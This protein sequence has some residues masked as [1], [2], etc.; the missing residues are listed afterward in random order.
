MPE[1]KTSYLRDFLDADRLQESLS[2][3]FELLRDEEYDAIA[4]SG[5]S[6]AIIAGALSLATGKPLILVRKSTTGCHSYDIVEGAGVYS[7]YIIV[8]DFVYSGAT[9]RRIAS[10]IR[11]AT[12]LGPEDCVGF[13]ECAATYAGS[14]YGGEYVHVGGVEIPCLSHPNPISGRTE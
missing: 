5:N 3:T 12:G 8:D 1:F 4:F 13:V 2:R 6:G 10:E 9:V 14:E 11:N 7:S